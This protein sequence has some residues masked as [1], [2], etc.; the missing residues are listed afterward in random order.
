MDA[1]CKKQFVLSSFDISIE[2]FQ[3]ITLRKKLVLSYDM[4]LP[5]EYGVS[6]KSLSEFAIIGV[7]IQTDK[8]KKSLFEELKEERFESL[9]QCLETCSGRYVVIFHDMIYTDTSGLMGLFYTYIGNQGYVVTSSLSILKRY[10]S[11]KYRDNF[12][13]MYKKDKYMFYP[14]PLSILQGV[15]KLMNTQFLQIANN[16]IR[17]VF[18]EPLKRMKD[19]SNDELEGIVNDSMI[20]FMQNLSKVYKRIYIQ[21]SGGYDSRTNFSI[22]LKSGI[23]FKS[24]TCIKANMT[25]CDRKLPKKMSKLMNVSHVYIKPSKL[26]KS[27]YFEREEIYEEYTCRNITDR[28]REYFIY[29]QMATDADVVIGG[30][31]WDIIKDFYDFIS[32]NEGFRNGRA[33]NILRGGRITY[34]EYTVSMYDKWME[35]VKC[36]PGQELT[37]SERAF[38]EIRIGGWLSAIEQSWGLL[39]SIRLQPANCA[40]VMSCLISIKRPENDRL[41]AERDIIRLNAPQLLKYKFNYISRVE[42]IKRRIRSKWENVNNTL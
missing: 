31:C 21:L 14:G 35:Y 37:L 4:Q 39:D 15:Y 33:I 9:Q 5:V 36:N 40:R 3:K 8:L 38:F 18:Y 12:Q 26:T 2:G 16:E 22:A 7:A 41:I 29:K 34:N 17:P 23:P 30:A 11:I 32:D 28:D 20:T 1:I 25:E 13:S 10:F 27:E 6:D 42:R 24:Y 19:L